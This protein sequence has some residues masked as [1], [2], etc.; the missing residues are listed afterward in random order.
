[1]ATPALTLRSS[2]VMDAAASEDRNVQASAISAGLDDPAQRRRAGERGPGLV[3]GDPARGWPGCATTASMRGPSTAPGQTALTRIPCGRAPAR[4]CGPGRSR[5]IFDAAYGVR[6][7][8]RALAGHRRDRDQAARARRDERRTNARNVRN[9]PSRSV[10]RHSRQAARSVSCSGAVGPA[11]PGVGDDGV[12]RAEALAA[13]PWPWRPPS[14]RRRRR[15]AA[16]AQR[17]PGLDLGDDLAAGSASRAVSRDRV[18]RVG[19]TERDGPPDAPVRP[20]DDGRRKGGVAGLLRHRAP[21]RPT[22][23]L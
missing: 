9:T 6:P 16:R 7:Y 19:E 10:A 2:P 18:A 20:G 12:H 13:R 11:M 5:A 4:A 15:R 3:L 21:S 1:M 22:T 14:P 23:A 8:E 17:R